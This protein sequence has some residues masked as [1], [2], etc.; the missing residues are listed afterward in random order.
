MH[1]GLLV[2]IDHGLGGKSEKVSS[3]S[4]VAKGNRRYIEYHLTP[5]MNMPPKWV[6]GDNFCESVPRSEQSDFGILSCCQM[7]LQSGCKYL[8]MIWSTLKRMIDS[9]RCLL[10][11]WLL[12][13]NLMLQSNSQH[14]LCDVPCV[15]EKERQNKQNEKEGCC[16]RDQ[17]NKEDI[18]LATQAIN[19][20]LRSSSIVT[21]SYAHRRGDRFV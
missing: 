10:L 11:D 3:L 15:W 6:G 16:Y 7:N 19:L 8:S 18:S 13:T 9:A 5:E 2:L 14:Y 4:T 17:I 12:H 20:P 21:V 1:S